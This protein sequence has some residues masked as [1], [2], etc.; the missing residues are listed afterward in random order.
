LLDISSYIHFFPTN[1]VI[2][3]FFVPGNNFL[4][5]TGK[6]AQPLRALAVLPEDPGSIPSTHMAAHNHL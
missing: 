4:M 3:S 6:M 1:R 5:G 2:S